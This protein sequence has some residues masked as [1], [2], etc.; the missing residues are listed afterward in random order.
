MN[1]T[2]I[3]TKSSAIRT[4]FRGLRKDRRGAELVEI[5]IAL[6][7]VALGGIAAMNAIQ[8]EVDGKGKAVA[9]KIKDDITTPPP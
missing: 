8:K 1:N 7:I 9:N 5:L 3:T 6:A 2:Q 4:F